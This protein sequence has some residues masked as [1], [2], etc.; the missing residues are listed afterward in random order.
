M[1]PKTATEQPPGTATALPP[2]LTPS[3][4]S[5][6]V[7]PGMHGAQSWRTQLLAKPGG[8]I[9]SSED[10]AD[11]AGRGQGGAVHRSCPPSVTPA[12]NM[13]HWHDPDPATLILVLY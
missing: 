2:S 6:A 7:R 13:V 1:T 4:R 3:G 11:Q 9:Q 10:Q 8:L 5:S 12:G